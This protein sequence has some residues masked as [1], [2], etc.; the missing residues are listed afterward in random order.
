MPGTMTDGAVHTRHPKLG[1]I[2]SKKVVLTSILAHPVHIA[3]CKFAVLV[4]VTTTIAW[5]SE[6]TRSKKHLG[7]LNMC[8]LSDA[9]SAHR[10][11]AMLPKSTVLCLRRSTTTEW[12]S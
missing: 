12:H 5:R 1:A 9:N 2:S 7:Q 11:T 3:Q 10:T 8:R 4:R 6:H